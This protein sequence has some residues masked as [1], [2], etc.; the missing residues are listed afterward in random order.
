M[1]LSRI[2]PNPFLKA[3]I[4]ITFGFCVL[5]MGFHLFRTVQQAASGARLG[6]FNCFRYAGLH[7]RVGSDPYANFTEPIP[8][9]VRYIDTGAVEYNE[10]RGCTAPGAITAPIQLL[11]TLTAHFSYPFGVSAF[12]LFNLGLHALL[13]FALFAYF[14]PHIPAERRTIAA[15]A[16]M[17][18]TL[19]FYPARG[20]VSVGQPTLFILILMIAS[21]VAAR[22]RYDVI[23]GI[24]LGF[25][26]SKYQVAIPLVM[27]FLLQRRWRIIVIAALVQIAGILLLSA[28]AQISPITLLGHYLDLAGDH[29]V[30]TRVVVTLGI[31]VASYLPLSVINL[32]VV[33]GVI[34]VI[35]VVPLFASL[36]RMWKHSTYPPA[37]LG[38]WLLFSLLMGWSVIAVYHI[39]PDAVMILFLLVPVL[40][41]IIGALP[42]PISRREMNIL[43]V[44]VAGV[45]LVTAAPDDLY[46]FLRIEPLMRWLITLSSCVLIGVGI[47]GM[48]RID[49][50]T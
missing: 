13:G 36:R 24:A 18:V 37:Y 5:M 39:I 23:A 20:V 19:A 41:L 31:N 10:T 49:A 44:I 30:N 25:A 34:S 1:T 48:R 46:Q 38:E 2:T 6:D 15:L 32:I 8:V 27:L 33:M 50:E 12:C 21:L 22:G 35:M 16:I 28:A 26:L 9:P 17:I 43:I 3:I 45:I 11:Y 14:R 7:I 40:L 47:V 29:A 4:I 42:M